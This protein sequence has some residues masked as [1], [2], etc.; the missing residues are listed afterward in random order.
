MGWD[1]RAPRTFSQLVLPVCAVR[2]GPLS[3]AAQRGVYPPPASRTPAR[4]QR[5]L[6]CPLQQ[7]EEGGGTPYHT[8]LLTG[9]VCPHVQRK[10]KPT[11][12][13]L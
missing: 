3:R 7:P 5:Q 8:E 2:E 6:D 1:K 4:D 9:V 13:T 10:A 11:K 12:L